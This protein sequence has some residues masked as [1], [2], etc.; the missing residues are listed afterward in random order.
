MNYTVKQLENNWLHL[1]V[2]V[3]FD[4]F[5]IYLG[6]A[7]DALCQEKGEE[8]CTIAEY[9]EKHGKDE[10]FYRGFNVSLGEAYRKII[11]ENAYIV[12]SQPKV[13]LETIGELGA[14]TKFS[15]ELEIFGEITLGK[16]KGFEIKLKSKTPSVTVDEIERKKKEIALSYNTWEE[17]ECPL[18]NGHMSVIDFE[19]SVDGVLFEGGSAQDYEL[20]IGSGMFIPGF[21]SQ[22]VGMVKGET[23]IVKVQFP[24]NYTPELAGKNADFKVTLKA[25]KVKV[26]CPVDD[27]LVKKYA[28]DKKL[29]IETMDQLE[30]I[31]REEIYRAKENAC[32][33]EIA[34]AIEDALYK[35]TTFDIPET[36]IEEDAKYQLQ[37]YEQQANMYGMDINTM[38]SMLGMKSASDL[39]AELREG[40]RRN[41]ALQVIIDAIIKA[42]NLE[43]TDEELDSYYDSL[44]RAKGV[45]AEVVKKEL[46]RSRLRGYI[47]SEKALK[48]VRDSSNIIYA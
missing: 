20:L 26:D 3:P 7:L 40:A 47:L 46:T 13:D 48:L 22:M 27:S 15:I 11:D 30:R 28:E 9:V 18:E 39:M 25:I 38:L 44:S 43:A 32:Q 14:E 23:R 41:F 34:G 37:S 1:D 16:Y 35:G 33:K 21:E 10:L 36:V 24:E 2:V 6:K 12:V 31:L 19:G 45:S 17:V 8:K 42:E 4:E 29:P 5:S